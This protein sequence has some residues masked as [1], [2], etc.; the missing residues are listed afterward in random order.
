MPTYHELQ[1][2]QVFMGKL[3]H[4]ADLLEEL[5]EVS[6]EKNISLG[7]VEAIGA[8]Q[9]ARIGYYDQENKEYLFFDLNTPMEML[10]LTGNISMRDGSPMVHAHIILAD[11]QGRACG[12]HLAPGTIIFACEFIIQA[13]QGP[14]HQRTHDQTTGLPLWKT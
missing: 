11:S 5:T 12:G 2:R 1:P 14:S 10:N 13:F 3:N 8:V 7:R 9:K 4:G 6:R